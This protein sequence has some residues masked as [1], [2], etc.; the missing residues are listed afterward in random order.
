MRTFFW[1][2][3]LTVLGIGA[4]SEAAAQETSS[5]AAAVAYLHEDIRPLVAAVDSLTLFRTELR[6]EGRYD[7]DE[8]VLRAEYH[9][10]STGEPR[11]DAEM[12]ARH[13]LD[14]SEAKFGIEQPEDD[15]V[16][17]AIK[18][19]HNS[20]HVTMRQVY[21]GIPVYNREVKVNLDGEGSPTMVLN[22]FA[23]HV[24]SAERLN[25]V[26]VITT[27]EAVSLASGAGL[28]DLKASAPELVVYP[29]SPP[30]LAWKLTAWPASGA[31]E[32]EVLVD[33]QTGEIIRML[34]LSFHAHRPAEAGKFNADPNKSSQNVRSM[35][36]WEN[37][38]AAVSI[39]DGT[40]LVFDPDPISSAGVPYGPPYIDA[41]DGDIPELNA[42]RKQVILR[43]ISQ[44]SDG[45]YRLEG[46]YAVIDD[47]TRGLAYT[48][49]AE[50]SSDAFQYTRANDFFEA[51]NAY[52]H[53]DK[54][55]RYVQSL[56]VGFEIK[57]EPVLVNPQGFNTDDSQY[58]PGGNIILLGTGGIDD[59]EDADVIWHEYAHVLLDFSAPGILNTGD[60][61]ALHEGWG[62]YW[63]ASYSR[64][65]SE[66]DP[67]VP[68]H[69]WRRVFSWDGNLPCWEG[70]PLDH[71]GHYPDQ[72]SY[73]A[74]GC[75]SFGGPLYESGML[76]ATTLMEIYPVVGREVLDRLNLASHAYI[77]Q[78]VTFSDAAH[79][80]IQADEDLYG[81]AHANVLV[82]RFASRG[83]V[84]PLEFGPVLAHDVLE[85][86]EQV[87]ESAPIK[88]TA[89]GT[90]ADVDSV[91]VYFGPGDA[92][93]ELIVL[94]SRGD[95][96]YEGAL[97]LPDQPGRVYYY[98]EAVDE[99]GRRR[100]LPSG[101]P[102]ETFSFDVG[103]DQAP[104]LVHHE[105]PSNTSIIGWPMDVFAEVT[106]NLGMDS[107][108]VEYE[109]RDLSGQTALEG[110]FALEVT[111]EVYH[112][113]FPTAD[114]E[115]AEGESVSYRIFARDAAAS[116]NV[117]VA[118]A[119]GSFLV[120]IVDDGVFR[121]Y[122]ME[123]LT[124]GLEGNGTWRRSEPSFGLRVAHSGD[125]VW[126]TRADGTYP[127]VPQRSTLVL[128]SLDLSGTD[129]TY[130][131][132]WHWY[133]FEHD[134][135]AEPGAFMEE[136][137]IWDGANV[138]ASVDGGET[139]TVL[140]PEGRYNGQ[141]DDRN[142]NPMGGEPGF[143]GFSYGWRQEIVPL[144]EDSNVRI[145]FDFGTDDGNSD[146]SI[147][148]AGWFVDDIAITTIYPTDDEPPSLGGLPDP[149]SVRVPGQEGTPQVSVTVQDDTGIE[150][151]VSEYTI[152]E[153]DAEESGTVRFTMAE[154]DLHVY[155]GGV[156]PPKSFAPGDRI[157][158][159]LRVR[160]FAGNEAVYPESEPGSDE[161]FVVNFRAAQR[162]NALSE[163]VPTG[164]WHIQGSTWVTSGAG[165]GSSV[166]SLVL[167]PFTLPSNSERAALIVEHR[168]D[169]FESAGGNL[170]ISSDDGATW[171]L[172]RPDG[173]YPES[174]GV[175]DHLMEGEGVFSGNSSGTRTS[176]F[177]LSPYAGER[178]RLRFDFAHGEPVPAGAGWFLQAATYEALSPDEEFETEYELEL[179][180][181]FPD[182][183]A[184]QT[185]IS[186]SV[187]EGTPVRL[188]VYD[189]LG[190]RVAL[191]RHAIQDEGIYTM[192]FDGSELANGV[193]MLYLETMQGNRTERMIVAR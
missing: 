55:Q 97:P 73:P 162:S 18:R 149:V 147:F 6:A 58:Q 33:A 17:T 74:S 164:A 69:D 172:V 65:L 39:V 105:P 155:S 119:E 45:L 187:S 83:Y 165:G 79:A 52:Y 115:V 70:R 135:I 157:E 142:G 122:D 4:S 125:N 5:R 20:S 108:W 153:G 100:R 136:A 13:Y 9:I 179:H 163:V 168:Y 32:W 148:F 76:W 116:G 38:S 24:A 54:S 57:N 180:A 189:M 92:E 96:R 21:R 93:F 19:G 22:G 191:I 36:T 138:K 146:R 102:T 23:P 117:T 139:W 47:G 109:I 171:T 110:S 167:E 182:P 184:G 15:L 3:L 129:S 143:G 77:A 141:I 176:V 170:K 174:Y 37:S 68:L 94:V 27:E 127:A 40:G 160:D 131:I 78:G 123:S 30:R 87:G 48:P 107:V 84:D 35:R 173:G 103:P 137:G 111:G 156:T 192:Q 188:S 121:S 98:I 1:I 72:L 159:R 16:V 161:V 151:L 61:S 80:I 46:P 63:A 8:H 154:T 175:Q 193:Y 60:G 10:P 75:V 12:A 190:R 14:V 166:S 150:A 178:I 66:E 89:T 41:D 183:F 7:L 158:Y 91:L 104:P 145:R 177:G 85:A 113:R 67:A 43:D 51:V 132:F 88:V 50:A 114:H 101:A 133:D 124:Q 126:A 26:P 86:T 34:D 128:P 53:V 134:G 29:S 62:D 71:P 81:G 44:G 185:T 181:N 106:D 144:P 118:P 49:P 56:E 59:A 64:Y 152:F 99:A 95:D 11:T 82:E 140:D 90:T 25:T 169:L 130:L 112:G 186:Y 120:S 31:V 42:E 28:E 2:S